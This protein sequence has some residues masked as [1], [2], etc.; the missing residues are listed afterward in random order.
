MLS[1]SITIDTGDYKPIYRGAQYVGDAPYH[2]VPSV[3]EVIAESL[4]NKYR[5]FGN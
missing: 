3:I 1:R 5:F 2:P 4:Y